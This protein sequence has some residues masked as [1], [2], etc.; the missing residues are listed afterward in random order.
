MFDG[1]AV[2]IGAAEVCPVA[3]AFNAVDH[4]EHL[5]AIANLATDSAGGRTMPAFGSNAC[6]IPAVMARAPAAVNADIVTGPVT[7][8]GSDRPLR[9][10]GLDRLWSEIRAK[11]GDRRVDCDDA[12]SQKQQILH[13]SV[14]PHL[15]RLCAS[16]QHHRELLQLQHNI[17][18]E[19]IALIS[20][21]VRYWS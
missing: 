11:C 8:R 16:W 12:C 6:E 14:I 2:L 18:Q 3:L 20:R 15:N 19:E 10:V 5:S 13:W 21:C 7:E 17:P 4:I 1:K 9:R